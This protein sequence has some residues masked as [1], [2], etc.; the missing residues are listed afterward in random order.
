MG[1]YTNITLMVV[2]F[3]LINKS[4]F[5]LA[6][7]GIFSSGNSRIFNIQYLDNRLEYSEIASLKKVSLIFPT[8]I[9][10]I[11]SIN[12]VSKRLPP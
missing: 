7:L 3:S 4:S 11:C 6:L 5:S 10:L 2:S 1:A 8:Q 9:I 12:V